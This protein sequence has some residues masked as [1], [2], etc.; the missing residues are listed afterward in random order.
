MALVPRAY[1][2]YTTELLWFMI[3]VRDAYNAWQDSD[4]RTIWRDEKSRAR[5]EIAL[6]KS[7]VTS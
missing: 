2:L 5:Y 3:N 6:A 1:S 4:G 7:R